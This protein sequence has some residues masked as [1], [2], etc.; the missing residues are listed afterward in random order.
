MVGRAGLVRIV[1]AK[2]IMTMAGDDIEG[3]AILGSHIV[4]GGTVKCLMDRFNGAKVVDYGNATILPGFNDAH[5]HLTM[6]ASQLLGVDLAAEITPDFEALRRRISASA[7]RLKPGE[8]LRASRYDQS[9]TTQGRILDR[10]QFD[11]LVPDNPAVITHVG[12]HWGVVNSMALCLA[13][14]DESSPDPSGGY[15]G[16]DNEGR[17][18]GYV[19]EQALFDFAY[20]SLSRR[21]DLLPQAPAADVTTTI[22]NA[23]RTLLSA[24]ITSVGDAMIGPQELRDLQ[25]AREADAL[26][27]RVNA[28]ITW[29]HLDTL[30][31][32]GIRSGFGDEWLRIGGVKV[33]V[34]GAIAGRSCA[35]AEP[36]EGTED[37]G[38]LTMDHESFREVAER[39]T[40]CGMRLAI[41]A[42]GERAIELV[43]DVLESLPASNDAPRHRIEHCSIVTPSI[44]R[45]IAAL[46]IIVVPFA[47][48]PSY[49][50][51]KLMEW[52]GHRRARRMFAHRWF[53]DEGILVAGSSDF[54]CGPFEPLV[55]IQSCVT[56]MTGSGA[57]FG[58]EQRIS[59]R[60]AIGLYSVGSAAASGEG[61]T[62][63]QLSPGYLADFVVLGGDLLDVP[64]EDLG[65]VKVLATWVGG[66]ERYGGNAVTDQ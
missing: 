55:G 65:L 7:S 9:A 21:L 52:Y 35:V 64:P 26:G 8:W 15:Y 63:G 47:S 36:F 12:A 50:G 19:S 38:I 20:P 25:L 62:K 60:E 31:K 13:N 17:L 40:A 2:R 29:P 56:R 27:V 5:L 30:G 61:G 46:K 14:V 43:L 23:S 16:R 44:L 1:R 3:I 59:L 66:Q 11:Q 51:D 6:M 10:S 49:H 42:N 48:Y 28:L 24:G 54:P 39:A 45:R 57:P 18:T 34:D 37:D 22:R 33:F 32:L 41:H 53:L 4:A 58:T